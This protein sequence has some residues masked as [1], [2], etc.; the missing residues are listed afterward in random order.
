MLHHILKVLKL[1]CFVDF[2]QPIV[3]AVSGG[4][5]S[6]FMLHMM[7]ETKIP[8]FVTH[9]NHHMRVEADQEAEQVKYWAEEMGLPFIYGERSL[10]GKGADHISEETARQKRYEFLF[11]TALHHQAQAVAVAHNAD[12]QVETVLLHLLRGCGLTGLTGMLY[13]SLPNAWSREIPLIR[14]LLATWRQEIDAFIEEKQLSPN[15]DHSNFDTK[16]L[17]N[18]VRQEL[19]PFLQ[20]YSPQVK[21]LIWQMA[22]ILTDEETMIDQL[23][24]TAWKECFLR[25]M[26]NQV[27]LNAI[28]IDSQ[29]INIQRRLVR[30]AISLLIPSIRDIDFG[31]VER[32]IT[33]TGRKKNYLNA[34]LGE[35]LLFTKQ[36]KR[37]IITKGE[38]QVTDDVPQLDSGKIIPIKIPGVITLSPCWQMV[39]GHVVLDESTRKIIEENKD[40][41]QL[42]LDADQVD[43]PL[44]LRRRKKGDTFC[45]AGMNGHRMKLSDFMVNEKIHQPQREKWPLL[46]SN[47][48]I[49][50]VAGRRAGHF[51]RVTDETKQAVHLK[52]V[53]L[54][55]S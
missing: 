31:I 14:P 18:R 13:Y 51:Y 19:I 46:V 30:K 20:T 33:L 45:P 32:F 17:R 26:T 38:F 1:N 16:L 41:W 34:D 25:N 55:H 39:V 9:Y 10:E 36:G 53:Q 8:L 44:V 24:E 29:K 5:D 49:L 6:L 22:E 15:I 11:T 42:W 28:S 2:K 27:E 54:Y 23:V 40:P 35:G 7:R 4:S 37:V 21:R 47:D 43:T 52:L 50:W 3:L 48:E 12:D